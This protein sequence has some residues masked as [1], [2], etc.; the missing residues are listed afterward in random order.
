MSRTRMPWWLLTVML[1]FGCAGPK[2]YLG[3]GDGPWLVY[4]RTPCFGPCPAFELEVDVDGSARFH[5][6]RNIRPEGNQV[7]IWSDGDMRAI[8]EAAHE[9]GFRTKTGRYDNPLV[10]D[11]PSKKIILGGHDLLD[12]VDGP[13][14]DALYAALDSLISITEWIPTGH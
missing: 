2:A 12:R 1:S 14:V 11:L 4:E 5:G 7:A 3:K 6:R 10:T 9:V 8:A 13:D